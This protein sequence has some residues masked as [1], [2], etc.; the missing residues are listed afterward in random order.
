MD[1]ADDRGESE[2]GL[3]GVI[4]LIERFGA[5]WINPKIAMLKEIQDLCSFG[6]IN[7]K[8]SQQIERLAD[9]L[10]INPKFLNC[11]LGLSQLDSHYKPN[12]GSVPV[13][14]IGECLDFIVAE[15]P[16]I[17]KTL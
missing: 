11:D 9:Y 4:D 10:K 17:G 1:F 5:T 6:L 3:Y 12:L 14:S 8:I 7:P 15:L 2:D 16:N 13:W